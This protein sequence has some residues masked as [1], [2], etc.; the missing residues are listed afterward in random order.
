MQGQDEALYAF[1]IPFFPSSDKA[2]FTANMP[3][4]TKKNI[5]YSYVAIHKLTFTL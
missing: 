1:G 5:A 3:Y 2:L 4:P